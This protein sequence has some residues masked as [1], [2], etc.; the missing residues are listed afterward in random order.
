LLD[1]SNEYLDLFKAPARHIYGLVSYIHD[2]ATY[3]IS[4]TNNLKSFKIERTS[5]E[6]K[7][8]GFAVSQK[9]TIEAIGPIDNVQKGDKLIPSIGLKDLDENLLMPYFYV[10]TVEINKVNNTTTITGYDILHKADFVNIGDVAFSY[11]MSSGTYARTLCETIGAYGAFEGINFLIREPANF[12]G[13]ETLHSAL[14]ALAEYTGTICYVSQEDTIRFRKMV[15]GDFTDVLTTADYYNLSVGEPTTLTRITSATELG[16]NFEVGDEG[17]TQALWENPFL[18]LKNDTDLLTDLTAIANQVRNLSSVDYTIDWRGCPAYEIGDFVILQDK[19]GNANYA[20]YF[21]ETLEFNG[22]LKASSTWKAGNG[23][24]SRPSGI[25]QALRQTYAKVD[26]VNERIELVAADVS[27]I[28]LDANGILSSVN[29]EFDKVRSEMNQTAS[30]ITSTISQQ[31]KTITEIRQ[32]LDGISLT[33]DKG[34]GTASITIGDVTV[35]ELV[36]GEYVDKTIAGITMDGYVTFNDLKNTGSTTINGNNITTGTISADR[37]NMTG[38]IT[39]SDLSSGCQNTIE[40][41]VGDGAELPSYIKSTYIDATTV[42]SPTIVGGS[43]TSTSGTKT[44]SI[45]DSKINFSVNDGYKFNVGYIQAYDDGDGTASSASHGIRIKGS[46]NGSGYS[47]GIKIE[48]SDYAGVAISAG[49]DIFFFNPNYPNG[50]SLTSI[51]NNSGGSG[52][53]VFG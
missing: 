13:D 17:F 44:T 12:R 43:L 38:A 36:N 47:G 10:D 23:D 18:T 7:F 9:I 20:F 6:G 2:G 52:S 5:P 30:S 29:D 14:T 37:I 1:V 31:D 35:S 25:S 42:Q 4:P 34:N 46:Y 49:T 41:M 50:I 21:S 22:G 16:N 39:W 19:E 3:S 40:G 48:S 51:I 15:G 27:K 32:D 28:Q 11:P 8:F 33:Y 26:K 45:S 53:A 24:T